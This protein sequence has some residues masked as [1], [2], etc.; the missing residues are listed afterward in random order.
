MKASASSKIDISTPEKPA[1]SVRRKGKKSVSFQ[2]DPEILKRLGRVAEMML[3]GKS[4]YEIS[5]AQRCSIATAKRDI[6]RVR[7]LW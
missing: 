3:E 1:R 6:G 5:T 7:E 4:L 2:D